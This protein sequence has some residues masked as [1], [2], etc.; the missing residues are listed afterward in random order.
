MNDTLI[1]SNNDEQLIVN[2]PLNNQAVVEATGTLIVNTSPQ[3]LVVQDNNQTLTLSSIGVQGPRGAPGTSSCECGAA[4][5][6]YNEITDVLADTETDLTTYINALTTLH[7]TD[8]ICSSDVPPTQFRL[9][10][11]NNIIATGYNSV[12]TPTCKWTFSTPYLV[13]PG[14]I[15]KITMEHYQSEYHAG[16]S[17][18]I[19]GFTS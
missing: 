3:T 13:Q 4:L 10:I 14:S 11:D 17:A 8:I 16:A 6:Q 9:L 15:A 12:L 2:Q 1:V 7:L 5:Y 19:I 18:T